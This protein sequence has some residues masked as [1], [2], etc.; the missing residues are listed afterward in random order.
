MINKERLETLIKQRKKVYYYEY[1][2]LN[3]ISLRPQ[4][5]VQNDILITQ[6][7]YPKIGN[8]LLL[9]YL[10]ETEEDCI[11]N[12]YLNAPYIQTLELPCYNE[13]CE[14]VKDKQEFVLFQYLQK[15]DNYYLIYSFEYMNLQEDDKELCVFMKGV[16][17]E[18]WDLIYDIEFTPQ[19]Y[20]D[21]L[22]KIYKMVVLK[23][24]QV[25]E[26]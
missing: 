16:T 21:F 4:D 12:K 6:I 18:G 10:F 19:N 8:E 26:E 14:L 22:N 20:V 1:N 15:Y 24:E 13:I 11:K 5:I 9:E 25:W 7:S 2:R 17:D 23:I 3:I